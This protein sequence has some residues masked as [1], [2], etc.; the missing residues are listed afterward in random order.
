MEQEKFLSVVIVDQQQESK[1][2]IAN[3]AFVLGLSAGREMSD[4]CFGPDVRDGSGQVHPSLTN[5]GHFVRKAGQSK[6]RTLRQVLSQHP[7]VR[8]IDYTEEAAPSDYNA[9]ASGIAQ[10][11]AEEIHYRALHVFG[12]E[13][14][15]APV[16]KN[17]SR[18][19]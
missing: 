18:L 14:V 11:S 16:T 4:T 3:A 12:P 10:K 17:L 5:I 7:E 1:G 13:S 19:D 15:V 8:L 9:Y 6:L 2:I